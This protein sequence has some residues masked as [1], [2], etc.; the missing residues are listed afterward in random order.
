[1]G[2][3]FS[4]EI[5]VIMEGLDEP[6]LV[7]V[8]QRDYAALETRT[9]IGEEQYTTRQRFLAWSAGKRQGKISVTWQ[10]FNEKLCIQAITRE[11]EKP[12]TARALDS[13]QED[14]QGL[15][16]GQSTLSGS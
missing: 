5:E 16:P 7:T 3:I 8:D 12:E 2:K 11:A 9:E 1:M 10:V 14:E 15:D 13:E 4:A 6:L